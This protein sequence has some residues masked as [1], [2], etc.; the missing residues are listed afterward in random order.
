MIAKL[1][2]TLIITLILASAHAAP[3][4]DCQITT[5]DSKLF[6]SSLEAG[7]M[8]PGYY[9]YR[10]KSS[11]ENL[12]LNIEYQTGYFGSTR[13]QPFSKDEIII[14]SQIFATGGGILN[15]DG[16]IGI[17]TDFID[18]TQFD[19]VTQFLTHRI[20]TKP[21]SSWNPDS[22][23]DLFLQ[24]SGILLN[25]SKPHFREGITTLRRTDILG[26]KMRIDNHP[27]F[28]DFI[29]KNYP[30]DLDVYNTLY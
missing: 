8:S 29:K 5:D 23:A 9:V 19:S 6:L 1:F 30:T 25:D 24:A 28:S 21:I 3:S 27:K 13:T 2:N 7:F 18:K 4:L 20:L 12:D 15:A 22:I 26:S 14:F 17:T 10:G 11:K 16:D